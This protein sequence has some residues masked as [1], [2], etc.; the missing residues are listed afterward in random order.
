MLV[1][2][3]IIATTVDPRDDPIEE[4][5][6]EMGID[7]FRGS[8]ADVLGRVAG[9]LRAHSV[10]TH[11]EFQGDNPLPDPMLVDSIIGYYLKNADRYDYVTNAM[12][13]TYPPGLEVY[14]Y[15]SEILYDAE[16]RVVDLALR[17]HVAVNIDQHPDRYRLCN[18][19]APPWFH[20]PELHLEV[21]TQEDLDV[22][23][24]VY[25]HFYPV[26]P[27]FGLAHVIDF[28]NRHK[29][30]A[31]SNSNVERRWEVFRKDSGA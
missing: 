9:A 5:A 17:E 16:S 21:D 11:V 4:L 10:D 25:E 19:E 23:S 2:Q 6:G 20:Y 7:C 1:D 3:I 12:K 24:A 31:L 8:E 13:T 26:N 28:A 18:L 29:E 27:G 30:L 15:P 22:V 14:V